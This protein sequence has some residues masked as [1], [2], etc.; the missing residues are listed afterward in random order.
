MMGSKCVII[1]AHSTLTSTKRQRGILF[2]VPF[3]PMCYSVPTAISLKAPPPVLE[4]ELAPTEPLSDTPLPVGIIATHHMNVAHAKSTTVAIASRSSTPTWGRVD[5][6]VSRKPMSAF[7]L[8][9]RLV[10]FPPSLAE[11]SEFLGKKGG[12]ISVLAFQCLYTQSPAFF[13]GHCCSPWISWGIIPSNSS[14]SQ[15]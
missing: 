14:R 5:A 4:A 10:S 1:G 6:R 12:L 13:F 2:V 11:V 9:C 15:R 8:Q 7:L 3:P